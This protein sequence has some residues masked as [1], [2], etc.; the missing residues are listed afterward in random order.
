MRLGGGSMGNYQTVREMKKVARK[1]SG[2]P[3]VRRTAES[4][5]NEYNTKS[6]NHLDEAKAV[7]DWVKRHMK[8]AKDPDGIEQLQSPN[9]MIRRILK[10]E[11]RGDCDDMALLVATLLLS[12]GIKCAYRIVRYKTESGGYNHIYVVCYESNY[13]E[14]KKRLAIDCIMKEHEIG[15]EIPHKSGKEIK[16]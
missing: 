10:G 14:P 1:Y 9:L 11:A 13:M 6:H 2:D 4:I 8:Y 5:L 15:Y 12:L 3:L 7:G 16:V